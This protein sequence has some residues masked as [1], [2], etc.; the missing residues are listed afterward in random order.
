MTVERFYERTIPKA[1]QLPMNTNEQ[2]SP[3]TYYRSPI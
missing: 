3:S 2:G 1:D